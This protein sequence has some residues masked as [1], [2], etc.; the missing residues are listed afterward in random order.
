MQNKQ[1]YLAFYFVV[2]KS[3]Q[4]ELAPLFAKYTQILNG[5][6]VAL[7]SYFKWQKLN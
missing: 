7:K 3:K 1:K 6:L 5:F 2:S 4:T